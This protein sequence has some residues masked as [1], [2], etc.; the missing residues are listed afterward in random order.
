MDQALSV[1]MENLYEHQLSSFVT[2][3]YQNLGLDFN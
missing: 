3:F 1:L 2:D